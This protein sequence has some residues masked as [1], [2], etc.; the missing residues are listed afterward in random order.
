MHGHLLRDVATG[1]TQARHGQHQG[2]EYRRWHEHWHD[3]PV[4]QKPRQT[5]HAN[6]GVQ[7]GTSSVEIFVS[8]TD[9]R[10]KFETVIIDTCKVHQHS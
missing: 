8:K 2:G 9:K 6:A 10:L 3:P 7:T 4:G 1:Q 5:G